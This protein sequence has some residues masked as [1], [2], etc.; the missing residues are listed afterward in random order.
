MITKCMTHIQDV[1]SVIRDST[2]NQWEY[3]EQVAPQVSV[4]SNPDTICYVYEEDVNIRLERGAVAVQDFDEPWVP[5][6]GGQTDSYVWWLTYQNSP[7][8]QF[9]VVSVDGGRANIPVPD[10]GQSDGDTPTLTERE[11]NLGRIFDQHSLNGFDD[12]IDRSDVEIV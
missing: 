9:V 2:P 4:T 12:Y 3:F 6:A 7:V 10:G 1:R 8:E 11:A 5:G